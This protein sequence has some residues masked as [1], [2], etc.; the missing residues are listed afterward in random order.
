MPVDPQ[1]IERLVS[2]AQCPRCAAAL[3]GA[4]ARLA[5]TSCEAVYP[6]VGAVAALL[7]EAE[8]TM[9]RWRA[10]LSRFH[11]MMHQ[12]RAGIE[13]DLGR[14]DLLPSVR[15]R[16]QKT[17]EANADNAQRIT[18]L[19]ARGGIAPATSGAD[20]GAD[21][22]TED[23][24]S[25]KAV[26]LVEHF[27]QLLRDW[28]WDGDGTQE[29]NVACERLLR[30][31]GAVRDL[32]RTIVLGA[33][34][35]RL[36][37][38]LQRAVQAPLLVALDIDPMLLL[39]AHEVMFGSGVQLVELPIDPTSASVAAVPRALVRPGAPPDGVV[40]LLADAFD[41]PFAKGTFSTVITPWF[42]D[43]ASEDFRE[44][45][46]V[47]HH[48]LVPG[49]RWIN[50][51]P[52]LYPTTSFARRHTKEEIVEL[53]TLSGFNVE[54]QSTEPTT[55]LRSPASGHARLEGVFGFVATKGTPPP[56]ATGASETPAWIILPHLPVPIFPGLASF[57]AIHPAFQHVQSLVD[58][59]RSLSEIALELESRV[60]LPPHVS[61]VDVTGAL[62]LK[63]YQEV[64]A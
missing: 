29:N 5:C 20:D 60:Q 6:S 2:L 59:E 24:S 28:G 42:I 58:G 61:P 26:P 55:Y 64:S 39:G 38:D 45:L 36:A 17:L 37:Y 54:H 32:G 33:G 18:A 51:G 50:Q 49:G 4:P 8:L 48:L 30:S 52:L 41:P 22:T 25:S 57:R 23:A 62:L 3:T 47:V 14:F 31:L 40:L 7:P 53:L 12:T 34:A 27:E 44:V 13:A 11:S 15:E 56:Q 63:V 1:T 16:L 9:T 46:A 43:V 10:Q 35:C 21:D 19:L